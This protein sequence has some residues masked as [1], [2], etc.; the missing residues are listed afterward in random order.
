MGATSDYVCLCV[1][2]AADAHGSNPQ[3]HIKATPFPHTAFC[4]LPHQ[5]TVQAAGPFTKRGTYRLSV[6]LYEGFQPVAAGAGGAVV[7]AATSRRTLGGGPQLGQMA[8]TA[9][10]AA[11]AAPAAAAGGPPCGSGVA[12]AAAAH[13]AGAAL[14]GSTVV[15]WGETLTLAGLRLRATSL[16]V[17]HLH[18]AKPGVAGLPTR[19]ALVAWGFAPVLFKGQVGLGL[20]RR[21][22]ASGGALRGML[23]C[24]LAVEAVARRSSLPLQ[25]PRRS[26]L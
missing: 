7:H 21:R 14:S 5:V 4:S 6:V 10:T 19:E 15:R 25:Y 16:L 9:P 22:P 3:P 8:T 11:A 20:G 26:H 17:F 18:L 12:T 13:A 24:S 23:A 1:L 2:F